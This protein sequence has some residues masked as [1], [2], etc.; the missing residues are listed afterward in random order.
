MDVEEAIA[1]VE[2]SKKDLNLRWYNNRW[3]VYQIHVTR[4]LLVQDKDLVTAVSRA[5]E[6]MEHDDA[7]MPAVLKAWT[8]YANQFGHDKDSDIY[9]QDHIQS[10]VV[11]IKAGEMKLGS[12]I[13]NALAFLRL[14]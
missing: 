14:T 12:T 6:I 4:R 2:Q 1:K 9:Y 10:W 8:V 3:I 13:D 5:F 11:A 7:L